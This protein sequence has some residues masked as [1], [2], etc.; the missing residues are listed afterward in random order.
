MKINALKVD[1]FGVWSRMKLDEL[2]DDLTVFC[3]PNE[4]GKTTLLQFIR[5]IL[6]GFSPERRRYLPPIQ[7]GRPGGTLELSG[8]EGVFRLDRHDDDRTPDGRARA[9]LSAPDGTRHGE[10]RLKTLL[11]NVDEPIFNNVFAVGLREMQALGTLSDTDAASL[12]FGLSIGLDRV[13]LVDVLRELEISRN[14]LLD[15]QGKPSTISKLLD[16]RTRLHGELENLAGLTAQYARVAENRDTIDVELA[17]LEEDQRQEKHDA[18]TLEIAVSVRDLWQQ[19]VDLDG[20]LKALDL[21]A[22]LT[23][24]LVKRFERLSSRLTKHRQSAAKLGKRRR[25]LQTEAAEL[26]VNEALWRQAARIEALGEQQGWIESLRQRIGQLEEETG[27]LAQQSRTQREA[28]GLD[29]QESFDPASLS[30][31]RMASLRGPAKEFQRCRQEA[32]DARGRVETAQRAAE[33]VADEVRQALASWGETELAGPLDRAS[34]LVAQ[35]RRRV[36][37]DDRLEQ[38][39]RYHDEL[40]RQCRRLLSRQ[41]LPGWIMVGLGLFFVFSVV[42]GMAGLFM[43]ATITGT[44]GWS[45][46]AMGLVGVGLAVATKVLLER[47]NARQLDS[48]QKQINMLQLQLQEAQQECDRLD[49]ALPPGPGSVD[50]RLTEAEKSLAGLEEL[51][52]VQTRLANAQQEVETRTAQAARADEEQAT[53]RKRWREALERAGLPT[54]LSPLQVRRLRRQ[55]EQL[56]TLEHRVN[57]CREEL[58]QRQGE[59]DSVTDR[60]TQLAADTGVAVTSGNPLEVLRRLVEE[61]QQ[62]E[63][64]LQQIHRLREDARRLHRRRQKHRKAIGRWKRR[65][66][67]LFARVRVRSEEE[68][69]GHAEQAA[70]VEKLRHERELVQAKIDAARG[71]HC[72][73][74]DLARHLDG[75]TDAELEA[76]WDDVETHCQTLAD[77]IKERIEERGRLGEQ[78]RTLAEDRRPAAKRMELST[79][80]HRLAE[81]VR[82][83]QVLALTGRILR[84]VKELYE[85]ERQP[86]TLQEASDYLR[87]LTNGRYVR[88]WTPLG[89]DVLMVDDAR[90]QALSVEVLSR[91]T[92][93]QL[94]L[95]LRLALTAAYARRGATLPLVLDDVLVNFDMPRAEAAAELMRDFA[96]A[97]HQLLVFTCHEHIH[98]LF[99]SLKVDVRRLPERTEKD[100][101]SGKKR[102]SSEKGPKRKRRKKKSKPVPL[103]Q[104][105][106]RRRRRRPETA[107]WEDEDSSPPEDTDD[108]PETA[109]PDDEEDS[110][111]QADTDEDLDSADAA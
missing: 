35:L 90:S 56:V 32:I 36:Q 27:Q 94:F 41:V 26:S 87:R 63:T 13:S 19:R 24:G 53:A 59:L 84:E 74:E 57:R 31:K 51:V 69:L 11:S 89:E 64:Q 92:R 103:V 67:E 68:F 58:E 17:R 66:H 95:A 29:A 107:P 81:A 8:P 4:A 98:K 21:P 93:E 82:R 77:R 61:V 23:G 108:G 1:G 101:A 37:L 54:R 96:R 6:Y 25:Q 55:A 52:P 34:S 7:G 18:R 99:K 3:G 111:D 10:Q 60:I 44:M 100:T 14:R 110:F 97:G 9:V 48:C 62:Q 104:E 79:V 45:M 78:L 20:R 83:W 73:D 42:L 47:S 39:H 43:P 46:A 102:S 33:A 76:R 15:K 30:S 91:G 72:T 12:L 22:G 28:L 2:S 40:E 75:H 105:Q 38:M 71:E 80:E 49:A 88:V 106:S 16:E 65:R 109:W 86:E 5:S 50:Q 85:K 70:E